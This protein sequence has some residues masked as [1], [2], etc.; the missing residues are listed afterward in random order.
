[1]KGEVHRTS[2]VLTRE[3]HPDNYLNQTFNDEDFISS[4]CP[5]SCDGVAGGSCMM[6]LDTRISFTGEC[7][8]AN[9]YILYCCIF[10]Y[11]PPRLVGNQGGITQHKNK[12][13]VK[14]R[15]SFVLA[16]RYSEQSSLFIY[17]QRVANFVGKILKNLM[18]SPMVKFVDKI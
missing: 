1:M 14:C 13:L 2:L 11:N 10:G 4:I 5:E 7:F 9:K 17:S 18:S 3:K 15:D 8:I 12:I 16:L 6:N